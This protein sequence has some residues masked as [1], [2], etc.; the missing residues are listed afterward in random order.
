[1]VF[2]HTLAK[3]LTPSNQNYATK[4]QAKGHR[5]PFPAPYRQVILDVLIFREIDGDSYQA[6]SDQA[7]NCSHQNAVV[8][9]SIQ[10][11]IHEKVISFVLAFDRTSKLH[12]TKLQIVW[13]IAHLEL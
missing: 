10:S 7:K 4:S 1:M 12:Q 11:G 8:E 5:F 9:I 2:D 6:T 13:K 3:E